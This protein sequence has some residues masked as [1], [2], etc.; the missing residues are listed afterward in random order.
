MTCRTRTL[1]IVVAIAISAAGCTS[2]P[3][4]Q[5]AISSPPPVGAHDVEDAG[6]VVIPPTADPN[7]QSS[8]L[9]AAATIMEAFARP[10]LDPDEWMDA[11]Y[12]LLTQAG[13]DAYIGT[14]PSRIPELQLTGTGHIIEGSTEVALIVEVPTTAGP[15]LVSLSRPSIDSNWLADRIRPAVP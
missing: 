13:A 12:P 3:A 4:E 6:E 11:M 14:D 7:S 2:A 5:P 15:Y 9:E 1:L 8:A 10:E